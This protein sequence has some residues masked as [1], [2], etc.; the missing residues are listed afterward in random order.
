MKW[1]LIILTA[2]GI[3]GLGFIAKTKP[4]SKQTKSVSVSKRIEGSYAP[5]AVLEL[6]TSEGMVPT[7]SS[8]STPFC[9]PKRL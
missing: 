1:I 7:A 9:N 3:I 6:F 5:V 8:V 2:A 4:G